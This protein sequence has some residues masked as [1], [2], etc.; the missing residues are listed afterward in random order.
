MPGRRAP[1]SHLTRSRCHRTRLP[2]WGAKRFRSGSRDGST[3]QN[4]S[5]SFSPEVVE[6]AGSGDIAYDRGTYH[7]AVDG[8]TGRTEDVGKYLTV[9]RKIGGEWRVIADT[10]NSDKPCPGQ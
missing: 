9:W 3:P 2:S 4:V 6:A 10:A 1:F 7:F 5:V 8:P